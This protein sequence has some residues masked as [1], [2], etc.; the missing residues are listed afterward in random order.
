[1]TDSPSTCPH[2]A[3]NVAPGALLCRFCDRGISREHY[4]NCPFCA[5]MIWTEAVYCRYCRSA[6]DQKTER[7][8]QRRQ[9]LFKLDEAAI[10]KIFEN[11]RSKRSEI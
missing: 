3:E 1:M 7:L 2:C 9:S 8:K 10:D 6:L 5:E 4:K 11:M